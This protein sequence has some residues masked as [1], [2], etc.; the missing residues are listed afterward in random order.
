[1]SKKTSPFF[2]V[3]S[4]VLMFFSCTPASAQLSDP[5]WLKNLKE[6]HVFTAGVT[7][8]F[9]RKVSVYKAQIQTDVELRL[10]KAGMRVLSPKE[11]QPGVTAFLVVNILVA[12][13]SGTDELPSLYAISL[14]LFLN[15]PFKFTSSNGHYAIT[16]HEAA[17]YLYGEETVKNLRSAIL[18]LVDRFI[19][20]YLAANPK[21]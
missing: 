12:E 16:W 19:N 20:D 13:F 8:D 11:H 9:E 7:S 18:D 15:Q 10:R 1:M 21:R 14:D 6:V 17:V 5:T 3:A 4:I 2:L